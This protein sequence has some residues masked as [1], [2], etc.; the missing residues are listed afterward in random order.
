MRI[1]GKSQKGLSLIE[2]I[3]ALVIAAIII[4]GVYR[5]FTVQ[6]KTFVVQEEVSEVQQSVRAVMDLIT[7]D[8]RMAGFGMPGWTVGGLVNRVRIDQTSPADFTIVGVFSA[9]IALLANNA[10]VGATAITL[11][12]EVDL[13]Q[14]DNLLIFESDRPVP[15][16]LPEALTLPPPLRYRTV[17]VSAAT[18]TFPAGTNIAIDPDGSTPSPWAPGDG[19]SLDV[20]LRTNALIYRVGTVQ[21][22]LN[23]NTLTR[24]ADVLATNVTSFQ[25]TDQYIPGVPETFGR[26]QIVL[27]VRT[28]TNDPDFP[29]GFRTRTLT[30]TIKARNLSL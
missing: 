18:G 29:D 24:N 9:P 28:R 17:V 27:T 30:S 20:T 12:E 15:P 8:I 21:Y 16:I 13:S 23:G 26:Y 1:L 14:E 2:M 11:S 7:R 5:T 25:I 19:D 10:S 22:Q 6:Q 4:A 3:I